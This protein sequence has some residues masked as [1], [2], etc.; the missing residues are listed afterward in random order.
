MITPKK[1]LSNPYYSLVIVAYN[2]HNADEEAM[3]RLNA[4]AINLNQNFNTR[5][6]L[7]TA[8]AP[9]F[10]QPYA[11]QHHLLCDIFYADEVPL[12][13]IVRSNPGHI[14]A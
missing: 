6:I 2:L 5:T 9:S 13:T 8:T 1:L 11:K 14:V 3:N 12:K 7:L 4:L 10:T